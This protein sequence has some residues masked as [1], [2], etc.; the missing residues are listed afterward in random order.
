MGDRVIL[1]VGSDRSAGAA[2][3]CRY[4]PDPSRSA[5]LALQGVEVAFGVEAVLPFLA[6]DGAQ[7]AADREALR[8]RV[9]R[10]GDRP[11]HAGELRVGEVGEY[12]P[13]G[14]H[15][16]GAQGRDLVQGRAGV[17]VAGN[18]GL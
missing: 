12:R 11:G 2:R 14:G 5:G 15:P 8:F 18:A 13:D 9:T 6:E 16:V 3:A 10:F 1:F 4:A 17:A 7:A